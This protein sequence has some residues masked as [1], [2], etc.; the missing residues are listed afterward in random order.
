[1]AQKRLMLQ[2]LLAERFG[3]AVHHETKDISGY[4][5]IVAKGGPKFQAAKTDQTSM[6]LGRSQKG[7]RTLTAG[8]SRMTGL[9]AL[10]ADVLGR[11]VAD[12]TGLT[13]LYDF[14]MEWTPDVGESPL[15]L[16]GN[17]APE[18]QAGT[19]SD[20]PSIFSAVQEQLGLR[21]EPRKVP[22]EVTV[23][24]RAQKPVFD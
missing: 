11:P 16:K 10:L 5:L 19:P 15:S 13:E 24:D 22:T 7:L 8:N 3:L 18:P 6:M 20:G 23:V 2:A 14:T 1:M 12:E 17:P 9:A 4:A 21:L